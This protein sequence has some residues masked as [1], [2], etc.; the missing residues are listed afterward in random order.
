VAAALKVYH[1][2]Q[3]VLTKA[4]RTGDWMARPND[5]KAETDFHTRFEE[6]MMEFDGAQ[7]SV[8]TA[9]S[10]PTAVQPLSSD[11]LQDVTDFFILDNSLRETSV[12]ASRGHTLEEKR[13][14]VSAMA[15][16]GLNEVIL[17]SFGS[18]IAV[19]SQIAEQ[20]RHLGKSF[21]SAWGFSDAY[22]W[23]GIS[24]KDEDRLWTSIPEWMDAGKRR[25]KPSHI[26]LRPRIQCSSTAA[27]TSKFSNKQLLDSSKV[28]SAGENSNEFSENQRLIE[29]V[30]HLGSS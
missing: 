19:D 7:K 27:P 11:S 29:G 14:I 9:L 16:T 25:E 8:K 6:L 1:E 5:W 2:L 18:K 4:T 24:G 23:T 26:S 22:D 28:L 21:D 10:D 15:E 30:F 3:R 20:W 12:G 17:G 13:Q